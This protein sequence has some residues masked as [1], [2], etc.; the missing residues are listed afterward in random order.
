MF[1]RIV[2]DYVINQLIVKHNLLDKVTE[3]SVFKARL[4]A[5]YKSSG[6]IQGNLRIDISDVLVSMK[7]E[8]TDLVK[9]VIHKESARLLDL[10][11]IA[12]KIADTIVGEATTKS[13]PVHSK[14][15]KKLA[16]R[17]TASSNAGVERLRDKSGSFISKTNLISLMQAHVVSQLAKDMKEPNA[18]LKYR[19]GRFA[20]SVRILN[21]QALTGRKLEVVYDYKKR[22]YSVFDPAVSTYMNLSLNP[23]RGLRN[24]RRLIGSALGTVA[25]KLVHDTFTI[26]PRLRR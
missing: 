18:P 14:L 10:G 20:N 15:V 6:M 16:G 8:V 21:V 26:A 7:D 4:D 12:S 9:S 1:S 13:T 2:E 23:G 22:P 5:T 25:K 17:A 19:S 3:S 11:V 24:P